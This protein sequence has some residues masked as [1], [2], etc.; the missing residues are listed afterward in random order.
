MAEGTDSQDFYW[1]KLKGDTENIEGRG[2][3]K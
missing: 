3:G 1:R 2:G